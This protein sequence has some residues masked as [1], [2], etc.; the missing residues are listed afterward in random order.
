MD[1]KDFKP[2]AACGKGVMHTGLP[3]FWTVDVQRWGIDA[4]AVRRQH[5]MEQVFGGGAGAAVA[6]ADIFSSG[7]IARPLDPAPPLRLL[8]C[9]ACVT[10][11]QVLAVLVESE[12][13]ALAALRA[14]PA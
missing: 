6:M 12:R 8:V 1:R 2:C 13:E 5:G 7:P 14:T 9:E 11:A 4:Q 3:L 10:Q